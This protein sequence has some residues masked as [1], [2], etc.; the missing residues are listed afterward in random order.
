MTAF[1]I[2]GTIACIVAF[3]IGRHQATTTAARPSAWTTPLPPASLSRPTPLPPARPL[4]P[5]PP[6]RNPT[7]PETYQMKK[8]DLPSV[9]AQ[10]ADLLKQSDEKRL[11]A[12]RL[13]NQAKHAFTKAFDWITWANNSFGMPRRVCFLYAKVADFF[14]KNPDLVRLCALSDWA[15]IEIL[16]SLGKSVS[17]F[18]AGKDLEEMTRDELKV[19]VAVFLNQ[20][21]PEK[22]KPVP[23][24]SPITPQ[25]LVLNLQDGTWAASATIE[26]CWDVAE[27]AIN[28]CC[29]KLPSGDDL[30]REALALA[31][32]KMAD[33]IDPPKAVAK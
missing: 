30:D 27:A 13:L 28:A 22:T 2:A 29:K 6:R 5:A 12:A 15:K 18:V 19:A 20:P 7:T 14:D 31:L 16:A 21:L 32:R 26:T 11:A 1:L 8:S 25:Q 23:A 10:I 9:A 24:A 3:A 17:A 33:R 4:P